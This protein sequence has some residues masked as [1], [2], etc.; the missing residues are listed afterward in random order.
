V[1]KP[2]LFVGLILLNIDALAPGKH[3]SGNCSPTLSLIAYLSHGELWLA[4]ADGNPVRNISVPG[5]FMVSADWAPGGALVVAAVDSRTHETK[6]VIEGPFGTHQRKLLSIPSGVSASGPIWAPGG[7][8]IAFAMGTSI[9]TIS[10]DG[11]HL[12]LL[13]TLKGEP[14]LSGWSPDGRKILYSALI[15]AAKS[16]QIF[17]IDTKLKAQ[18]KNLTPPSFRKSFAT[19]AKWMPDHKRIAFLGRNSQFG[20][21]TRIFVFNPSRPNEK[22]K[23][24]ISNPGDSYD[25][26]AFSFSPDGKRIVFGRSPSELGVPS[27]WQYELVANEAKPFISQPDPEPHSGV[28]RPSWSPQFASN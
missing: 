14:N 3:L 24:L 23:P 18:P 11:T 13:T 4:G 16:Q 20:V 17:E 7:K 8:T 19:F 25:D 12:Q 15:P 22:P 28:S 21:R 10:P 6:I 9:W 26:G 27:I 5:S 1:T 2:I